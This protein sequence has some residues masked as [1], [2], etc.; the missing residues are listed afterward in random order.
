MNVFY[1]K[2]NGAYCQMTCDRTIML[3]HVS[4]YTDH[5]DVGPTWADHAD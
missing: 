5:L 3:F 4:K 1:L 2:I